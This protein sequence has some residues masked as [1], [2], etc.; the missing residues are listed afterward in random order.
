M[1]RSPLSVIVLGLHLDWILINHSSSV[2]FLNYNLNSDSVNVTCPCDF[3]CNDVDG[4]NFYLV[5][6]SLCVKDVT[7]VMTV[8]LITCQAEQSEM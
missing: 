3:R 2:V 4:Q 1:T 5:L 6:G 8:A 7:P